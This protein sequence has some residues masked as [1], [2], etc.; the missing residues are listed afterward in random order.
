M[1]APG[2]PAR[3]AGSDSRVRIHPPQILGSTNVDGVDALLRRARPRLSRCQQPGVRRTVRVQVLPQPN[4]KIARSQPAAWT[5]P[6][7][8]DP[9]TAQCVANVL[10]GLG[11]IAGGGAG[12]IRITVDL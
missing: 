10:R 12:I 1:E 5:D 8:P 9:D 2:E 6:R 4:G 3:V 7:D 11:P